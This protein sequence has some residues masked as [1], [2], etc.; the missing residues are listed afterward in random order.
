M[1]DGVKRKR[2]YDASGRR[3]QARR[4]RLAVLDAAHRSFLERG[5]GATTVAAVAAAAGVSVETVYKAFGSK[6]ALLKAVFDVSIAGDDEPVPL[7]HR[8]RVR[9][10]QEEPDP[11]RKLELYGM[12]LVETAPR[13]VPVQLAVRAAAATDPSVAEIWQQMLAERLTGMTSFARHLHDGGH[14]RA[15]VSLEEARDV[16]WAYIST[17]VYE[18]LVLHRGWTPERYARWVVDALIAALLPRDAPSAM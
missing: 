16:L 8:E 15:G 11:R 6:G 17:E 14:L 1:T 13:S 2:R 12:H 9:R 5:Y 4:N 10:I 18:L 7:I 3:D